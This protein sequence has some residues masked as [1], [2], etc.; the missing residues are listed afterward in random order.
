MDRENFIEKVMRG[1]KVNLDDVAQNQAQQELAAIEAEA[2]RRLDEENRGRESAERRKSQILELIEL[3]AEAEKICAENVDNERRRTEML[4]TFAESELE[5]R[6]KYHQTFS[7]FSRIYHELS[8]EA[9]DFRRQ[10][11]PL[12]QELKNRGAVLDKLD[13]QLTQTPLSPMAQVVADER[14]RQ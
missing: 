11:N 1:E 9:Y 14:Y 5:I 8:G 13:F 12:L 2:H 6:G 4:R 3:G 10:S 7:K